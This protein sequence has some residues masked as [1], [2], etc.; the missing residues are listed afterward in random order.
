M[1]HELSCFISFVI[2]PTVEVWRC[3]NFEVKKIVKIQNFKITSRLRSFCTAFIFAFI[4]CRQFCEKAAV[5]EVA[6]IVSAEASG[7]TTWPANRCSF[8]RYWLNSTQWLTEITST[9][10]PRYSI[11]RLPSLPLPWR[12]GPGAFQL[13]A[14]SVDLNLLISL[15]QKV[16]NGHSSLNR[17][18]FQHSGSSRCSGWSHP[19]SCHF[20]LFALLVWGFRALALA[21]LYANNTGYWLSY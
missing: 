21:D 6:K 4:W 16:I 9:K 14:P 12:S 1:S 20:L 10:S 2:W 17:V 7:D 3:W 15:K 5:E 11:Y 13:W 8:G 19:C 18:I